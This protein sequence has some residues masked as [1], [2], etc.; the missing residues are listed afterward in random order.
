MSDS[1]YLA[2]TSRMNDIGYIENI[3]QGTWHANFIHG[4]HRVCHSFFNS[5]QQF[6]GGHCK[7]YDGIETWL[8]GSF[9]S[10]FPVNNNTVDR[11]MVDKGLPES[12]ILIFGLLLLQSLLLTFDEH[13]F[14]GLELLE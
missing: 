10:R 11:H 9:M 13:V 12:I 5:L 8:E 1:H 3:P 4:S 2:L 6:Y 14:V 7:F